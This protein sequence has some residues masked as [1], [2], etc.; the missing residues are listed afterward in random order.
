VAIPTADLA[1]REFTAQGG[2]SMRYLW[3]NN[4]GDRARV[5]AMAASLRAGR[6]LPPTLVVNKGGKLPHLVDGYHRVAAARTA[7]RPEVESHLLVKNPARR[8]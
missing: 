5:Q 6:R 1:P 7:G 3:D 8:P 2:V 4:G